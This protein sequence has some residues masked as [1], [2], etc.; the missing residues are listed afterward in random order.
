MKNILVVGGAGYIGAHIVDLLCDTDSNVIVFDNLSNGYIENLNS[1]SIFVEG[2]ILNR[3]NIESALRK[4]KVDIVIHM[5]AKKAAGESMDEISKY[6]PKVGDTIIKIKVCDKHEN[7]NFQLK[8][9]RKI[10]R[11]TINLLRNR[12]IS[13]IIS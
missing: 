9:N 1:K 3:N 11:K 10:D 2:D 7:F 8:N 4:Y 6:L 12:E 5:A 13:T